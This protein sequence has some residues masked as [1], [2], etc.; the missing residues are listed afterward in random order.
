MVRMNLS[1][2]LCWN[3]ACSA[4]SLNS[5]LW[6]GDR[7][8]DFTTSGMPRVLNILSSLGIVEWADVDVVISTSG[9]RLYSSIATIDDLDVPVLL[10]FPKVL[11]ALPS[12]F[13]SIKVHLW[14]QLIYFEPS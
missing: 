4:K 11:L 12:S 1:T 2:S 6:S 3:P 9:K 14:L 10:A 7:L 13:L 5:E 8:S